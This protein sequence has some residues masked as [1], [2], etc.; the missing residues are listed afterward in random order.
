MTNRS[1]SPLSSNHAQERH[2]ASRA[3]RITDTS[4]V[5]ASDGGWEEGD[6]DEPLYDNHLLTTDPRI[7][8]RPGDLITVISLTFSSLFDLFSFCVFASCLLDLSLALAFST[9]YNINDS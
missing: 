7:M 4:F 1:E 2:T 3:S 8:A 6:D 9:L 5:T